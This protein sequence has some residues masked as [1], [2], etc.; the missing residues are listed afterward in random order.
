[1]KLLPYTTLFRSLDLRTAA[2]ALRGS[3]NGAVIVPGSLDKSLLWQK[4]S[5]RQMPPEAF[6]SKLSDEQ[7]AMIRRWIEGGAPFDQVES[8]Q[9]H[10]AL[11]HFREQVQPLFEKRCVSCHGAKNPMAS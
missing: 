1:S 7:I 10:P 11:A 2:A 5:Q 9:D 4:V 3:H 8:K 6:K